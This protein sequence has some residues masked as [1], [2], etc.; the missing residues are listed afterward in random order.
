MS[1]YIDFLSIPQHPRANE[2][3]FKIPTHFKRIYYQTVKVMQVVFYKIED[4][5]RM[6]RGDNSTKRWIF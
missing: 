5:Y 1:T 4:M 3:D 6:E 2:G